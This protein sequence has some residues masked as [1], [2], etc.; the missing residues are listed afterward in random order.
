[1]SLSLSLVTSAS[2]SAPLGGQVYDNATLSGGSSPTGS[3]TFNLFGPSDNTCSGVP[4]FTSSVSVAGNG[5]YR[6]AGFTPSTS[7]VYRWV[8]SY[9]GDVTNPPA[10]PGLCADPAEQV[11]ILMTDAVRLSV[12]ASALTGRR[13]FGTATL[14]GGHGS[15]G[16][17]TFDLYG[18]DD[19]TCSGAP[20]FTSTVAVAGS[21]NYDSARFTP[22]AAGVYRWVASFSGGTHDDPAGPTPCTDPAAAVVVRFRAPVPDFD[23]NGTTDVAVFRPSNDG[24]Y[25][26]SQAGAVWGSPGDIPVPG[27]YDGDGATDVAV[28][29]PSDGGWYVRGQVGRTW[30]APGDIPVP[31]DYDGDGRTDLAVFRPSNRGWYVKGQGGA[32][33][34]APGDIPVPAD[35]DGDGTT[36]VAVFRPSNGGWYV[37]GQGGAVWGAPGDIPVPADYDGDGTTDVAVFRSSNGGW[38]VRGQA[39]AV[40]GAPG[41][42]PVPGDYDGDRR[43]DIAVFRPGRGGWYIV[44]QPGTTWGASTD[45]PLP[46]PYAVWRVFP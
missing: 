44:G 24:W 4:I 30:G 6:S 36:D 28:F 38:Y 7:G 23:G 10:G 12:T 37:K 5:T 31:G 15:A 27:D 3:I 35:Y 45:R 18:P 13:I 19:A 2:P 39:G 8:A 21:G 32:V 40:W 46:L 33:W 17:V 22:T 20:I 34:G 25:V 29:R 9:S 16:T 1:M 42:I 43:A 14:I 11:S 41:D 26:A